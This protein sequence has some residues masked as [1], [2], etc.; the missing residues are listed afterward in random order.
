MNEQLRALEDLRWIVSRLTRIRG[1]NDDTSDLELAGRILSNVEKLEVALAEKQRCW[2]CN[3]S[4]SGAFVCDKCITT[5]TAHHQIEQGCPECKRLES[6]KLPAEPASE[7]IREIHRWCEPCAIE[8]LKD[9]PLMW[10]D[11]K[12]ATVIGVEQVECDSDI[13]HPITEPVQLTKDKPM[14]PTCGHREEIHSQY[15]CHFRAGEHVPESQ[16]CHCARGFKPVSIEG[17]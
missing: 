15:R 2:N 17:T 3:N 14:C 1:T 4:S 12:R 5:F 7:P 13:T 6:G 10:L 11:W 16:R 9:A 8:F